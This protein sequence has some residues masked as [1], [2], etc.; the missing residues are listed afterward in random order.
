MMKTMIMMIY[1]N[2]N[3][4]NNTNND[5]DNDNNNTKLLLLLPDK[6]ASQML[7][8]IHAVLSF[9]HSLYMKDDKISLLKYK[10]IF[11]NQSAISF[12]F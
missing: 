8:G 1:N 6:G 4:D 5:N 10:I 3:N 2:K 12:F 7:R 11:H 9:Q